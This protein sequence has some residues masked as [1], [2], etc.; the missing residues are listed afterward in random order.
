M[1][2]IAHDKEL[3]RAELQVMQILWDLGNGFVNDIIERIPGPR[4]AYN[5]IS[6]I[7]RILEK[8]GFAGHET[9]GKSHRYYPLVSK[10][11]YTDKYMSSV[12]SNFFSDSV[13]QMVSF[14]SRN[15][16]LSVTEMDEIIRLLE[17]QK[18]RHE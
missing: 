13:T 2:K 1:A 9:F 15:E 7:V 17:Q 11:E 12:L 3:T 10:P 18:N 4:P 8:K 6:T 14:F 5:T 16:K